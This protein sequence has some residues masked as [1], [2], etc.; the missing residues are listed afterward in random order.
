MHMNI[1]NS[2]PRSIPDLMNSSLSQCDPD[3]RPGLHSNVVLTGAQTVLSAKFNFSF[4]LGLQTDCTITCRVLRP[5]RLRYMLLEAALS[6][7][8]ERGWAV[9]FCP[10]WITSLRCG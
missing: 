1:D 5:Q 9:V 8:L 3:L 6:A 10:V 7:N 2:H 4:F